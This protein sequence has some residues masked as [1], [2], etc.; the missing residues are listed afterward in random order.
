MLANRDAFDKVN[1]VNI[2]NATNCSRIHQEPVRPVPLSRFGTPSQ[3]RA[4][5]NV[6]PLKP[7]RAALLKAKTEINNFVS[8]GPGLASPLGKDFDFGVFTTE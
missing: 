5:R 6:R 8:T 4:K 1:Y 3:A 2:R 7:N